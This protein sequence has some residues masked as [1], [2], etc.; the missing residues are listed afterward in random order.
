MK[1]TKKFDTDGKLRET[2]EEYTMTEYMLIND[3]IREN[4]AKKISGLFI[5]N[6]LN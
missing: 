3:V 6:C 1:I 2:V 4:K 5:E